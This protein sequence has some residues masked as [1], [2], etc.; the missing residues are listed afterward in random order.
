MVEVG[1]VFAGEAPVFPNNFEEKKELEPVVNVASNPEATE[2]RMKEEEAV[3]IATFPNLRRVDRAEKIKKQLENE[4]LADKK[5]YLYKE[6]FTLQFQ[7]YRNSGKSTDKLFLT[8]RKI[9]VTE[10]KER[11]DLLAALGIEEDE[12]YESYH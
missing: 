5:F 4:P 11:G 6:L 7:A 3:L 10:E 2:K 8:L 12:I 1:E 9:F